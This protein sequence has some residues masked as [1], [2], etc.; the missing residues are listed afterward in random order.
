M[1]PPKLTK[2]QKAGIALTVASLCVSRERRKKRYWV[3]KWLL[4]RKKISHMSIMYY[5]EPEDFSNFLRMGSDSF[6]ELL[7]MVTPL[8]KKQDTVMRESITPKERLVVTLRVLATGQTY[9]DLKFSSIISPQILSKIIPETCW[10]I[11][12]CL[13]HYI[14]M[15]A[16]ENE[17]R[18]TAEEFEKKWHFPHCVG[19]ID[20]KHIAIEKP[21]GS[22]SE[23]HNYKKFFSVVL[24]GVVNA[25]YEFIYVNTGTNGSVSDGGVLKTTNLYTKLMSG[26]LNL[27]P[28]SNLPGTT[29]SAPYVFVGDS[30]FAIN[31]NIMKP[32]PFKGINHDQRIFN[33][34][35]SRARRVV[36]NAFGILA[37]RFRIFRRNI[38]VDVENVDAI[39]LA[40]CSLHNYLRKKRSRYV[41][42]KFI[43]RESISKTLFSRGAWRQETP[44]LVSLEKC[45]ERQR[46]VEGNNVRNT[47]AHFF[48]HE[49]S[50]SFQNEMINVIPL[51]TN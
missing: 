28:P 30:A 10:A 24:L 14:K 26:E 40:C 31:R 41:H 39:V 18:N 27:P 3:R 46:N 16:T 13:R 23:F 48:N 33:Y 51:D 1:G 15:P 2:F 38:S 49:G 29:T 21:S 4:L 42:N 22:G 20:G 25:N 44:A 45:N 17:W 50:V 11:Y 32:Y 5:L 6:E 8:I 34:R 9:E 36:E 19:A 43:D 7:R 47:F 35:L 12:R 37:A